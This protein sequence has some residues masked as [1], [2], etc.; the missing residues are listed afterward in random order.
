[1]NVPISGYL[2]N[3]STGELKKFLFNPTKLKIDLNAI[4]KDVPING[5][6]GSNL[7]YQRTS[8][9]TIPVELWINALTIAQNGKITMKKAKE[10]IIN[11]RN[12]LLSL[13]AP[14]VEEG[15]DTGQPPMIHF[16]WPGIASMHGKIK[17]K[18]SLNIARFDLDLNS[19]RET[20]NFVFESQN[21]P[22]T[23]DEIQL[24]GM[25]IIT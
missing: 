7:D 22:M 24:T 10:E 17:G 19:I 13:V 21:P 20:Y 2:K 15:F 5:V 23:S 11:W 14:I 18:V 6:M 12:F 25:D 8:N 1:M 16:F 9:F 4:Y 3:L